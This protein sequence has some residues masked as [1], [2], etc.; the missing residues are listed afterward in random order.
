MVRPR[1]S[2]AASAE[3]DATVREQVCRGLNARGLPCLGGV[4]DADECDGNRS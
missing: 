4:M 2:S 3:S 1:R